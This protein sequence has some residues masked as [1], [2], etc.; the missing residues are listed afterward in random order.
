MFLNTVTR[1][2]LSHCNINCGLKYGKLSECISAKRILFYLNCRF[3]FIYKKGYDSL[4]VPDLLARQSVLS[5]SEIWARKW[6][7]IY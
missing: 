2:L 6:L 1:V 4:Q 3:D 5:V 7:K